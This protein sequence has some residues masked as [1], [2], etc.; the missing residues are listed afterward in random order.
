LPAPPREVFDRDK[1][2]GASEDCQA[3]AKDNSRD[4]WQLDEQAAC[5]RESQEGVSTPYDFFAGSRDYKLSDEMI[6]QITCP[7]LI[8]SPEHEQFWPGQSDALM[9]KLKGSKTLITFTEAEGADSHVEPA[10]LG[11]RGERIFDW[12]DDQIPAAR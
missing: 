3:D 10:A 4:A 9:V 1:N 12:L 8:T 6:S 5:K 7:M 11:V 2:E